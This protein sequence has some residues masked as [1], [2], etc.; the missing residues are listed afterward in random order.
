MYSGRNMY[1]SIQQSYVS[2]QHGQ[3]HWKSEAV[4]RVTPG[5]RAMAITSAAE[6][7][8]IVQP[9]GSLLTLV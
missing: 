7:V 1:S 8:S 4:L 6:E 9:R 3:L 2:R 5:K